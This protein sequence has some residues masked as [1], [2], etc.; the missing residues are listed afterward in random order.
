M[1]TSVTPR[2]RGSPRKE[3]DGA[4]VTAGGAR[5]RP[6]LRP[7]RLR[8]TYPWFTRGS[9]LRVDVLDDRKEQQTRSLQLQVW[10]P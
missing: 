8:R 2:G 1:A 5:G 9:P 6:M 3:D 10:D 7:S 4:T